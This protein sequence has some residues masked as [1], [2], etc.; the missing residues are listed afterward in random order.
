VDNNPDNG[1]ADKFVDNGEFIDPHVSGEVKVIVETEAQQRVRMLEDALVD[2]VEKV[3]YTYHRDGLKGPLK[4]HVKGEWN[5]C[6]MVTCKV[7]QEALAGTRPRELD[8]GPR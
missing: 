8:H 4:G 1:G 7:A 5:T 6:R 3:H 2:M